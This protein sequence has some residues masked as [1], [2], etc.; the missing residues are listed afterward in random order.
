M[1][2]SLNSLSNDDL[3]AQAQAKQSKA[4]I[5]PSNDE[6]LR[7]VR[8]PSGQ[9][10]YNTP[11]E[12]TGWD[13]PFSLLR[14]AAVHSIAGIAQLAR[15]ADQ[16]TNPLPSAV[17]SGDE[18][19]TWMGKHGWLSREQVTPGE[20]PG[21]LAEKLAVQGVEGALTTAPLAAL[22]PAGLAARAG[23]LGLGAVGSVLGQAAPQ[24][25]P[26]NPVGQAALP[27]LTAAV[28]IGAGQAIAGGVEKTIASR[29]LSREASAAVDSAAAA[30]AAAEAEKTRLAGLQEAG[31][32]AQDALRESLRSPVIG[33]VAQANREAGALHDKIIESSEALRDATVAAGERQG[34]ALRT[35]ADHAT[36]TVAAAHGPHD[37]L[38]SAGRAAQ[39]AA[40]NWVSGVLPRQLEAAWTP[41]DEL[42]PGTTQVPLRNFRSALSDIAGSAGPLASVKSEF[43]PVMNKVQR[44][45]G[46]LPEEDTGLAAD[47]GEA[48]PP[49]VTWSQTKELRSAI[50]EALGNP[51]I[52]RDIP[53]KTLSRLYAALTDDMRNAAG[54]EGA[55]AFD[56]ANT[57]SKQ[58][59]ALAEGPVR[60]LLPGPLGEPSAGL[61]GKISAGL[62]SEGKRDSKN[63]LA[64]RATVPDAVDALAAGTLRDP[65]AP[66]WSSLTEQAQA[67]L[68]PNPAHRAMLDA[69]DAAR[70]AADEHVKATTAAA[71]AAHAETVETAK[72][73]RGGLQDL[74]ELDAQNKLGLQSKEN[75]TRVGLAKLQA[76]TAAQAAE[77]A[78]ARAADLA[79]QTKSK[80]SPATLQEHFDRFAHHLGRAAIGAGVGAGANALFPQ[81]LEAPMAAA[82]GAGL[83]FAG[84]QMARGI[85]AIP[86]SV[87]RNPQPALAGVVGSM[88]ALG[89]QVEQGAGGQ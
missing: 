6:L 29:A 83:S 48:P 77:T 18:A 22:G 62:L 53:Q 42:V 27:M 19:L 85:A 2:D 15:V 38:E 89:G 58:L 14:N 33:Q 12:Y 79:E 39:T 81:F 74:V 47:L 5:E 59:F 86:R 61:P 51:T 72:S 34:A 32:Q 24:L 67:A 65:A 63:L 43:A 41:V 28:P 17:P 69:A 9:Q 66:K 46:K 10:L 55:G 56:A 50:G 31:K 8:S 30:T 49:P 54:E 25:F 68:V 52:L 16:L 20:G 26:G 40:Q 11:D 44:I 75:E 1:E 60:K 80:P 36:E 87:I 3:L 71:K 78:K 23:T 7:S 21:G 57:Q 64:L 88:N 82:V 4:A 70:V 73:L 45:L 76:E 13:R 84:P 37:S 35:G